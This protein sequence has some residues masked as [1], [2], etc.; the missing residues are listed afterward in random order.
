MHSNSQMKG[1]CFTVSDSSSSQVTVGWR[2]VKRYGMS[3]QR[4]LD[5]KTRWEILW[6]LEIKGGAESRGEFFK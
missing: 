1:E 2:K 3:F 4:S 5:I 6:W